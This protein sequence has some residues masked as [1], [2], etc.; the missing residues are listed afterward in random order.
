M[1]TIQQIRAMPRRD[2]LK[3]L[4]QLQRRELD[5]LLKA[6][7]PIIGH[8]TDAYKLN[9]LVVIKH[10]LAHTHGKQRKQRRENSVIIQ[11]SFD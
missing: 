8:H 4:A 7:A 6:A 11:F 5:D 3:A 10:I 1:L 9:H 2:A